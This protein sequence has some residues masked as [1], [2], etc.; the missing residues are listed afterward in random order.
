MNWTT[1]SILNVSR[2]SHSHYGRSELD[3]DYATVGARVSL[4]FTHRLVLILSLEPPASVSVDKPTVSVSPFIQ[5][6]GL[7]TQL[8]E[9]W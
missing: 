2:L 6:K 5:G 4:A 7:I 9:H 8:D 3:I 1:G